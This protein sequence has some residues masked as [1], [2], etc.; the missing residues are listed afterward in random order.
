MRWLLLSDRAAADPLGGMTVVLTETGRRL[1]TAGGEVHWITGRLNDSLP[2]QGSWN[3]IRVHSFLLRGEMGLGALWRSRQEM[4]ARLRYLL[5]S[6]GIDAAIV[7]QPFGGLIAGPLLQRRAVPAVYFFHSPWAE[8]YMLASDPPRSPRDPGVR[9]RAFLESRALS[10]FE[11]IAVFSRFMGTRL[12]HHHPAA[13]EPVPVTPGVD[14]ERFRPIRDREEARRELGWPVEGPILFSLRRLVRRT[15]VDL[16]L[17]A[18]PAVLERHPS[19]LLLIGGTGPLRDELERQ[20]GEQGLSGQIRFLGYLPD[21]WVPRALGAADLFVV[22]TRGLEGLGL[23]TLEAFA[24]GTPVVGTPVGANPE[25]L[26][27]V[28]RELVASAA[29]AGALA[30][31][32]A[33]VLDRGE[34]GLRDLGRRCRY[35]AERRF[36]WEKTVDDLTRLAGGR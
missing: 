18:L 36:G 28:D 22:P 14:L 24:S 35:E 32:I 33:G 21:A 31:R 27:P 6:G 29:D 12:R 19:T 9:F 3:G 2:E 13:P 1:A 30:E 20:T 7:H 26:E 15:G 4:K 23:V 10:S 17:A 16:L 8:E 34:P 5:D 25:L 11:R